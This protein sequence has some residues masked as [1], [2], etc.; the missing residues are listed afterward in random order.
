[1]DYYR[2]SVISSESHKNQG[3]SFFFLLIKKKPVTFK[4][5]KAVPSGG[6]ETKMF[7]GR[8][9]LSVPPH[10]QQLEMEIPL[11]PAHRELHPTLADLVP[12]RKPSPQIELHKPLLLSTVSPAHS[13]LLTHG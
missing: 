5:G 10:I 6:K 9:P 2:L 1:M 13:L 12:G 8:C 11:Y 3:I 7:S 4:P